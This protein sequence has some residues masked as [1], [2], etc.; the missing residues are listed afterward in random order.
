MPL[1]VGQKSVGLGCE[2]TVYKLW[3]FH[4]ADW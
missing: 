3:N 4:P 2:Y 1:S